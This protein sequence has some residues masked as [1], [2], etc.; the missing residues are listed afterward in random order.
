MTEIPEKN[1]EEKLG[2]LQLQLSDL[3]AEQRASHAKY[4]EQID[5]VCA[6]IRALIRS[7]NWTPQA[8]RLADRR[9]RVLAMLLEERPYKEIAAA[10]GA[11]YATVK[12]DEWRLR[13]KGLFPI[14]VRNPSDQESV[15]RNH[16]L[17]VWS[18]S[19][20]RCSGDVLKFLPDLSTDLVE[21]DLRWLSG[22]GYV[23]RLPPAPTETPHAKT[24][25][26]QNS[27]KKPT[28]RDTRGAPAPAPAREPPKKLRAG[29][30]AE[31]TE[32]VKKLL[33]TNT[34]SDAHVLLSTSTDS[35]HSHQVLVNQDG[36]GQTTLDD[37]GHQHTVSKFCVMPTC[38]HF[39]EMLV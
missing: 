25:P 35:G 33:G 9:Q 13:I 32:I 1:Q 23:D 11:T 22:H 4:Q 14:P 30:T 19:S 34:R 29:T 5:V 18:Y 17:R 10:L 3:Q 20:V 31:L 12:N 6:Q 37:T 8:N 28:E 39:H 15:R 7:P 38:R 21:D 26:D 2:E 36:D 27:S 24:C 16:V